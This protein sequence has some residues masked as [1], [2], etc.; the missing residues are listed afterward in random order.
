LDRQSY[1]R[2]LLEFIIE[3]K[4]TI[5][6]FSAPDRCQSLYIFLQISRDLCFY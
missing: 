2:R 5:F 1:G 3:A 6:Y 4:T